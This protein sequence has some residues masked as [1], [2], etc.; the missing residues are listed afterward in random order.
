LFS[1]ASSSPC[2]NGVLLAV[3]ATV[4]QSLVH[5]VFAW[6]VTSNSC[7]CC[8]LPT[9]AVRQ[10]AIPSVRTDHNSQLDM[11]RIR[12]LIHA[13]PFSSC[14]AETVN[15]SAPCPFSCLLIFRGMQ[16]SAETLDPQAAEPGCQHRAVR[17]TALA[18]CLY[19]IRC[20]RMSQALPSL[21]VNSAWLP[22]E[23]KLGHS[24][25]QSE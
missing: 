10:P 17:I 5:N 21:S 24:L 12:G 22:G 23:K 16:A 9:S 7:L 11:E 6:V 18:L 4:H 15:I 1:C 25:L 14:P 19:C 13:V 2:S 20:Q 3:G 8:K